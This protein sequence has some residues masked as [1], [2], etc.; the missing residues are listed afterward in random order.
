MEKVKVQEMKKVVK[1]NRRR[2]SCRSSDVDLCLPAQPGSLEMRVRSDSS[3]TNNFG[4]QELCEDMSICSNGVEGAASP[5]PVEAVV[6]SSSSLES[7]SM[8]DTPDSL[9]TDL[10]LCSPLAFNDLIAQSEM[11]VSEYFD[12]LAPA[13]EP[14]IHHKTL[15]N[16]A[17]GGQS[18]VYSTEGQQ[19]TRQAQDGTKVLY[20][21][22]NLFIPAFLPFL[23]PT[24]LET[25]IW[26][27]S[28]QNDERSFLCTTRRALATFLQQE[29]LAHF[30]LTVSSKHN[31]EIDQ[32]VNMALHSL[33]S[34]EIPANM[35]LTGLTQNL[36]AMFWQSCIGALSA[37]SQLVLLQVRK[38]SFNPQA[39]TYQIPDTQR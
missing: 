38:L 8:L 28:S 6:P 18:G 1:Q 31:E 4:N 20:N 13:A 37:L 32:D 30:G 14:S 11:F 3:T 15:E 26:R 10:E 36:P 29:E 12:Q 39:I 34:R 24:T 27:T 19:S 16:N 5:R 21:H 2:R 25:L 22:I 33:R 35:A 7:I 17:L 23:D 9:Y